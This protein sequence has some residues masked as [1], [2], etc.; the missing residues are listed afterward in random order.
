VVGLHWLGDGF[1]RIGSNP[2]YEI[3]IQAEGA[4]PLVGTLSVSDQG[5]VILQ[6]V[7]GAGVSV[8]GEP[9]LKAVLKSDVEGPPDVAEVAG[10]RFYVI[11]RGGRLAVRV[12]DPAAAARTGFGGIDHFP[13]D[14]AF[15]V[16]A[17]MKA[18]D[19]PKE[20]EMPTVVGTPTTM[21]APGVLHFSIDG[22]QLSLE[23]YVKDPGDDSYLVIFTDRTSGSTSYGGGRYL[24][25]AAADENGTTVLDFNRAY[26]PPC[27]FTPHATCPL[28]TR[29]NSLPVAIEAGERFASARD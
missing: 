12:K 5:E 9:T 11:E 20:V 2:G 22:E 29:Q 4:P 14:P 27:A 10:I 19:S 28:P 8:N 26:N 18:H 25:V 23:P 6:T 16:T 3:P 17:R 15:R 1:N 7:G 24:S 13:I 21:L